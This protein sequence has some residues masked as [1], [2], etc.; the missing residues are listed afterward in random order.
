MEYEYIKLEEMTF[1]GIHKEVNMNNYKEEEFKKLWNTI[2]KSPKKSK[3]SKDQFYIGLEEY[4]PDFSNEKRFDYY[5]MCPV[6]CI[7]IT[8]SVTKTL[9]SGK[10]IRFKNTYKNHGPHFFK[11]VYDFIHEKGIS[12]DYG[13]D[14]E[15]LPPDFTYDDLNSVLYVGLKLK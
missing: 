2:L 7:D 4:G 14:F 13:F 10:Y 3:L 1:T 12:I 11:K 15:I 8:N 9:P 6:D 5:A